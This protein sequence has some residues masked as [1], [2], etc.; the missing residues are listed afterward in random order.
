MPHLRPPLCLFVVA[1]TRLALTCLDP[2]HSAP[3]WLDL[4]RLARTRKKCLTTSHYVRVD[5][6]ELLG[7]LS[8]VIEIMRGEGAPPT[9]V[10]A[11]VA[12]ALTYIDAELVNAL[13]LRRDCCSVSAV[14]ALQVLLSD[15][16]T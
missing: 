4:T 10:R 11:V 12:G 16:M 8:N 13:V 5:V 2:T 6:Q 3:T 7:G 9:A 14:K 15:P 1:P